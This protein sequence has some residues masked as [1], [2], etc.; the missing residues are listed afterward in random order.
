MPGQNLSMV[1]KIVHCANFDR[2]PSAFAGTS[3][4]GMTN[5]K[6]RLQAI[7][8]NRRHAR[9]PSAAAPLLEPTYPLDGTIKVASPSMTTVSPTEQVV[10]NAARFF[11]GIS[12]TSSTLATTVSPTLTGALKRRFWL[13]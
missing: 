9:T 10:L 8:V 4:A 11:S 12:S 1:V 13:T 7:L 2:R 6:W 5:L 3:F